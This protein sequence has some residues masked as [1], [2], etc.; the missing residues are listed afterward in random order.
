MTKDVNTYKIIREG[1]TPWSTAGTN[2]GNKAGRTM[3]NRNY[4]E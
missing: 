3:L 1:E 2:Q 4:A